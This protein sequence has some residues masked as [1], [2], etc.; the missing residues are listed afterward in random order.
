MSTTDTV[1]YTK[2][3][4]LIEVGMGVT[5]VNI[6]MHRPHTVIEV[7]Q[8]GKRLKVQADT[9]DEFTGE[10]APNPKG[11][12]ETISLRKNGAYLGKGAPMVWYATRYIIGH[13]AVWTDYSL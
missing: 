7:M 3:P 10:S 5:S 6:A 12:I 11:R 9:V 8:G 13:R 1:D 4:E 2:Q